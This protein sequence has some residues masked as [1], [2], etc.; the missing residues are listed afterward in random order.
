M[1]EEDPF[2]K[3]REEL[4]RMDLP[5]E[6]EQDEVEARFQ[7]L[8]ERHQAEKIELPD[9]SP[10]DERLR[11]LED[12]VRSAKERQAESSKQTARRRQ[13]EASDARGMGLGLTAAYAIIGVPLVG[14]GIG[15][16]IDQQLA[17]NIWKGLLCLLGAVIGIGFAVTAVNR[18]S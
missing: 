5:E 4:E 9:T 13:T 12:K 15:W 18:R 8:Q 16:L 6:R 7:D 11:H 14:A 10:F 3:I 1:P 2:K 17:T